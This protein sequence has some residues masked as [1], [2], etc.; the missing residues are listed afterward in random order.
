MFGPIV[1]SAAELLT[2]SERSLVRECASATCSW[3]FV[4]RTKNHRRR[5]CTTTG[6]GNVAKIRRYRQQLRR[7][8]AAQPS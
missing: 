3:L 5:W 4:D 8:E 1:R 2:S 7:N 6:C